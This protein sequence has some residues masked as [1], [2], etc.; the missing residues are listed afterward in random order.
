MNLHMTGLEHSSAPLVQRERLTFSKSAAAEICRKIRSAP[1]VTGCVLLATCNRTELYLTGQP[2]EDITDLIW[3]AAGIDPVPGLF[4]EL[5]N[6]EALRHLMEVAAGL[7][8]RIW[9]EDQIIRQVKSAI[10]LA[11]E[12]GTADSLLETLFR[13]AI[14]AGKE[15]RS[16]VRLTD[17]PVSAPSA[18]VTKIEKLLGSLQGKSAVVIGNGEMDRH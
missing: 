6:Q 12:A 7:C 15:I 13:T 14:A 5:S 10:D 16:E 2:E 4:T 17:V 1:G 11:R 18:A 3:E 9:G 8:S